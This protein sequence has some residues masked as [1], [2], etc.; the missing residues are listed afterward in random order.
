MSRGGELPYAYFPTDSIVSLLYVMENSASAEIA[1]IGNVGIV[2][3]ALI[4]G[5]RHH[6]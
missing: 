5:W 6:A 1:V 3:L 4:M 2:G